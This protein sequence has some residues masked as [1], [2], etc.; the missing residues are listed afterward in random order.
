VRRRF[1]FVLV[2]L[3]VGTILAG[4]SDEISLIRSDGAAGWRASIPRELH[5]DGV[6]PSPL[7]AP[8]WFAKF[9]NATIP[10][11][12][13]GSFE[14]ASARGKVLL[15]DY[16]ASWCGPCLQ[17]L[18][19]LQRLHMS[20]SGAGLVA[21]A[22]NADEDA[23]TASESAKRLGL[24]MTIG[25]NDPEVGKTLGI[26]TL[27]TLVILDKQGRLRKRWDGYRPGLENEIAATVDKLLADDA[28]GTTRDVASVLSGQGRLAALWS[29][30]LA[31][32]ADGVVGLPAGIEGGK[33]VVA[34]GGGELVSFDGAAADGT[35]ELVGFRAGGTAIDVIA[36]RSGSERTIALPAPALD[37]AAVGQ[38]SGDGRRL[39]IATL[40]GAARA[41]A[42]DERA[43]LIEGAGGVRSLAAIP[44]H[45]V[46]GLEESGKIGVLDGSA[47][48]WSQSAVGAERL[49]DAE[50]SGAI[51][52]PRTV[53]AAV[54]G[55]FLP[56]GGRQLAVATY[57]GHL[58]ILDVPTGRIVFDAAWPDVHELAAT[59][60]DGDGR[61]ELL[62]ASARS[63]TALSAV[64]H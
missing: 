14:L 41:A 12:P 18:P 50:E 55:R 25:L 36:L 13:Q 33:R 30:D 64:A 39:A 38:P 54:S 1:G 48:A 58:T 19:H 43:A 40:R 27:P 31:G 10:L 44:G 21:L 16:W 20:R 45:G 57:A 56:E 28:T 17:E 6:V 26:K 61:D 8:V 5:R 24:T 35:R 60:L 11:A 9:P 37:V 51:A 15:I 34:S 22:V 4:D 32:A 46:V 42:N 59:D 29:R 47:P 52:G 23:A 3:T 62:V 49:L 2:A 63:V 53:V 7:A